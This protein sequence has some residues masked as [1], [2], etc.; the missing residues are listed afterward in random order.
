MPEMNSVSGTPM[1]ISTDSKTDTSLIED[2]NTRS[3]SP[4]GRLPEAAGVQKQLRIH[5]TKP[6]AKR[7]A[8]YVVTVAPDRH[9]EGAYDE[10]SHY[11][12]RTGNRR[13]G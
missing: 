12:G 10:D 6:T 13:S 11:R 1:P 4:G 5:T 7:A 3:I 8:S 2:D 9:S